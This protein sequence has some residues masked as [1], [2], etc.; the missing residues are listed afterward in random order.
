MKKVAFLVIIVVIVFLNSG[1]LKLENSNKGKLIVSFSQLK[2]IPSSQ[3]KKGVISISKNQRVLQRNFDFPA[4]QIVFDS[5]EEGVWNVY[6]QILDESGYVLYKTTE[7]VKVIANQINYCSLI[8]S[9]NTA[10]LVLNVNVESDQPDSVL[11]DL[12]CDDEHLNDQKP[13]E[14]RTA[15]FTFSNIKSAVWDMKLTLLSGQDIIMIVPEIGSYGLELQP[16]RTNI[17]DVTID[18]FGNLSVEVF[19][20]NLGVVN[21]ATLTN[22]EEG[23]KIEWDPVEGAD[24][25]DLYRKEKDLWLKLNSTSLEQTN[26]IDTNVLEGETYYY[27]I[28]AKSLTGLQSGFSEIFSKTRDTNRIFVGTFSKEI[29]RLKRTDSGFETVKYKSLTGIPF[30]LHTKGNSLYVVTSNIVMELDPNTLETVRTKSFTF[31]S[32]PADFTEN[33]LFLIGANRIY[34]LNLTTFGYDEY[35]LQGV[36]FLSSDRYLCTVTSAGQIQIRDPEDPNN[37]IA[38]ATGSYVFT[39]EDK[40]F[41]YK[42]NNLEYYTIESNNLIYKDSIP[43]SETPMALDVYQQYAYLAVDNGFYVIN[44]SNMNG[45]KIS[46]ELSKNLMVYENELFVLHDKFLKIFDI[47]NPTTP[48]LKYSYTFTNSGWS[49]FVD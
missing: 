25:Y 11:I 35:P 33:Y 8:L 12:F 26:F 37:I 18:R 49:I 6:V 42:N 20:P 9:L 44:L 43:I 29:Y 15:T 10:D 32:S 2:A 22:L 38:Q 45:Q 3:P 23:I 47:S 5:I 36:N 4:S 41:I 46:L 16:G 34:R 21:N 7:Q 14:N 48:V 1:C 17:F 31:I 13:L 39:K 28:N 30:H 19:V 24:S 40:V 27:V